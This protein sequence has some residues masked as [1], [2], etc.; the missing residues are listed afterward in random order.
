MGAAIHLFAFAMEPETRAVA[1]GLRRRDPEL[2][3]SLIAQYEH[4]LYRYLLYLSGSREMARD[5]FQET[6]LR[7]LARG[8]QYDG[9]TRFEAWLFSIARHL[10]IDLQRRKQMASL[11][12]MLEPG[13]A[14][15]AWEPRAPDATSPLAQYAGRERGEMLQTA[16]AGLLP[17]YREVLLLRFQEELSLEEIA[18]VIKAPLSTVKS[19]LYRGLNA[20]RELLEARES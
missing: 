7:V 19:R 3:D 17:V 4:R 14:S 18:G 9:V 12:E 13:E 5:L 15:R 1:R 10:V 16:L 2:L 20:A 8:H 11:D 6:W